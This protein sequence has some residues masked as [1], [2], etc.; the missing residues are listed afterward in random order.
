[1]K[2]SHKIF[3]ILYEF[4]NLMDKKEKRKKDVTILSQ[5]FTPRPQPIPYPT[6]VTIHQC[7]LER[8]RERERGKGKTIGPTQESKQ[9]CTR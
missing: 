1:M 8:E 5:F 6:T 3:F 9:N 7:L 4:L 2:L